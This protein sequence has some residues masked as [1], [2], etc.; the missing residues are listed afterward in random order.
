MIKPYV[1]KALQECPMSNKCELSVFAG[2]FDVQAP[3]KITLQKMRKIESSP[4]I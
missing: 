4:I 3:T 2:E 1:S